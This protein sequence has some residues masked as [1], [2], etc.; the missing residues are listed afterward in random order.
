[1]GKTI[2]FI[3]GAYSYQKCWGDIERVLSEDSDMKEFAY[4]FTTH[5]TS[6]ETKQG[7]FSK[8][9]GGGKKAT[10]DS[11][12]N[13]IVSD[14][15]KLSSDNQDIY[16]AA[17]S[18][19]G[20]SLRKAMLNIDKDMLNSIV[21]VIY[22]DTPSTQKGF[23]SISNIYGKMEAEEFGV[24]ALEVESLCNEVAKLDTPFKEMMIYAAYGRKI[25][26]ESIPECVSE[27]EILSLRHPD[28]CKVDGN[29]HLGY[30][31]MKRFFLDTQDDIPIEEEDTK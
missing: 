1:M 15:S 12:A 30:N 19:G 28:C 4:K 22:F 16:I 21:K 24:D 8:L 13:D 3:H 17:H 10:V 23:K 7:I 26:E 20:V 9:F 31:A 2:Y 6:S 14:I 27:Y 11:V 5:T 18:L 29:K 25:D